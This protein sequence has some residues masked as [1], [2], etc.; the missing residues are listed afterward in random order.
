MSVNFTNPKMAT[1]QTLNENSFSPLSLI[2]DN[3]VDKIINW[4]LDRKYKFI[5]DFLTNNK[6]KDQYQKT[7]ILVDYLKTIDNKIDWDSKEPDYTYTNGYSGSFKTK[8]GSEIDDI[9][10]N[11]DQIKQFIKENNISIS[12]KDGEYKIAFLQPGGFVAADFQ[13]VL[14]AGDRMRA[15][16]Y[17]KQLKKNQDTYDQLIGS[18]DLTRQDARTINR[19]QKKQAFL[20]DAQVGSGKMSKVPGYDDNR[21]AVLNALGTGFAAFGSALASHF[22]TGNK[23][24]KD[25]GYATPSTNYGTF[26][27]GQ[28]RYT[29]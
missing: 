28:Q 9:L 18:D 12:K 21:G 17:V 11:D 10:N 22:F 15:N 29:V 23:K 24:R 13:H 2:D 4:S 7:K 8:K 3:N 27:I 5:P 16:R 14:S 25:T 19:Y 6:T 26:D 1:Y 20:E